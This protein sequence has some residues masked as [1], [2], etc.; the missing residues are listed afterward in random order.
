MAGGKETPRQKMIGMMYLVL[1]A[2]LALNVSK[3][4]VLAFVTLNDKIEDSTRALERNNEVIYTDIKNMADM[5]VTKTGKNGG[6]A[7]IWRNTSIQ[8]KGMAL[9]LYNFYVTE[10]NDMI[11]EV[12]GVDW[13]EPDP[14]NPDKLVIK[15]LAGINA[16]DNYDVATQ[17]FVKDQAN[18]NERGKTI[19]SKLHVFRDSLCWYMATYDNWTFPLNANGPLN[20]SDLANSL[21]QANPKDTSRIAQLFR[22][23]TLPETKN[24]DDKKNVPYQLV[25]FDHAPVV[26]AAA[27]FASF[28]NEVRKAE[29]DAISFIHSKSGSPKFNFDVIE[30]IPV[31]PAN[32]LNAGDSLELKIMVAAY[33]SKGQYETRFV[34]VSDSAETGTYEKNPTD[35]KITLPTSKPGVY[36]VKG[37]LKVQEDGV[38]VWKPWKS[39]RYEVGQP[40]GVVS[41]ED[42]TVI[43]AGYEHTFSASASGYPQDRVSLSMPGVTVGAKGNGKFS[44]KA[45]ANSVGQ[46]IKS[47]ISI[48]GEGGRPLPGPEFFVKTLPRPTSFFGSIP[49]SESSITKAQIAANINAGVKA[50]YD[51][52]MPLDPS[53]VRFTVTSFELVVTVGGNVVR[54]SAPQGKITP[55]MQQVLNAVRPGMNFSI[56]GIRA[57]GPVGEVRVSPLSFTVR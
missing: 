34:V 3:E 26:A 32:Y 5:E 37:E 10:E 50:G 6:K 17:L 56:Q 39:Y 28:R 24:T 16:K 20:P 40:M 41:N 51:P 42:L 14:N 15:D 49:N 27:I 35:N 21:A 47:S 25:L 43:Y 38:D 8:I 13:M 18:P 45:P 33:D 30:P 2:L 52:S 19:L 53:K 57:M 1:T 22:S 4:I 48:K 54:E 23:I 7:D 12:E 29:G 11:K 55:K 44:V 46:K 31:A 9:R 36:Y